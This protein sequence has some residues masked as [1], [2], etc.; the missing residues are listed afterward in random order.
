[1]Y[2]NFLNITS[3]ALITTFLTVVLY[4]IG[5]YLPYS[6]DG[7]YVVQ[8][9]EEGLQ[10]LMHSVLTTLIHKFFFFVLNPFGFDEL[11]SIMVSSALAGAI[12]LQVLWAIR[13]HP[14]FIF[15]NVCAGS[16]LVFAGM[17]EHY[18]WVNCCF[19]ASFY[20]ME[21]Y[22]KNE[23]SL[24][25]ALSF[26]FLGCFFHMMLL[27]YLPA[28]FWVM[29]KYQR[30]QAWEFLV[31]FCSLVVLFISCLLFFPPEGLFIDS[32]RLVPWFEIQR[33]GQHFTLFSS[34][35]LELLFFFHLKGAFLGI[36]LEIPVLI[37]LWRYIDTPFN[38]FLLICSAIGLIWTTFWHPDLGKLDWDLFS[39]MYIA[40]HVLLGII[41]CENLTS[42]GW[43]F[44][45]KY[46]RID[47]TNG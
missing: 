13:P 29:K 42:K 31:P 18:A 17:V 16:F 14:V 39:Q 41:F 43:T 22:I 37:L 36:P 1:M 11:K 7:R 46:R 40:Q 9:V 3:R 25:P 38:A 20:W 27:F 21:K 47:Q 28:Y 12:A 19:L 35:H 6:G 8:L 5:S 44:P 34:A 2:S 23:S 24:Y 4:Q 10:I 15:V 30:F 32:S 33:K 26:L 45:F